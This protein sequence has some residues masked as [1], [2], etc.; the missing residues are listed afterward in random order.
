MVLVI[1]QRI[2]V[3]LSPLAK[4]LQC[5]SSMMVD[6]QARL[7][8]NRIHSDS[9]KIHAS[10]HL[11]VRLSAHPPTNPPT[12]S[13][14]HPTNHSLHLFTHAPRILSLIHVSI[15][16]LPPP[17]PHPFGSSVIRAVF[18][19]L[20]LSTLTFLP[21]FVHSSLENFFSACSLAQYWIRNTTWSNVT[22]GV[23]RICIL[24]T[25]KLSGLSPMLPS[26]NIFEALWGINKISR[27][28]EGWM[29]NIPM[30][31]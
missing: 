25:T 27:W 24:L 17:P 12:N 23:V 16:S 10:V 28:I 26:R 19:H 2:V 3:P 22:W 14:T 15:H 6:D 9:R 31:R 1:V 8:Q 13:F 5:I 11:L 30:H 20:F 18:V 4:T 7:W 21:S 29:S